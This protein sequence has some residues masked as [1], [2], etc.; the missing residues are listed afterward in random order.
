MNGWHWFNSMTRWEAGGSSSGA[1][2]C[3]SLSNSRSRKLDPM[4]R[5]AEVLF[6]LIMVLTFTCSFSVAGA[7]REEVRELVIGA[8]GCNF[9]WGIIDAAFYLLGS[10]S[11]L[12]QGILKLRAVTQAANPAD[13]HQIIADSLP[14]VI[15]AVLTSTE[16]EQIREKLHRLSDLPARPYLRRHDWVGA[17]A[18]FLIVVFTTLPVLVPFALI[19]SARPALRT[20]NCIAIVMLFLTGYAFGRHSG[21]RPLRMGL[22]MVILGGV[23][24]AIAISLGG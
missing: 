16:L 1:T 13:A 24:V 19:R 4:D 3:E 7:G 8:V 22:S 14:P 6:A 17:A 5:I 9:A 18:V 23:L 2:M 20:S 12:G 21:H 11:M 15:A 10:F